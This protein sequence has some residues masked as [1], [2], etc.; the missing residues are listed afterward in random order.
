MWSL[1]TP[2]FWCDSPYE[3][4][5][6]KWIRSLQQDFHQ[7]AGLLLVLTSRTKAFLDF[8]NMDF[9]TTFTLLR[10]EPK[11]VYEQYKDCSIC[12]LLIPILLCY[13]PLGGSTEHKDYASSSS[14]I[15]HS[16]LAI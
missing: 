2:H 6:P 5:E 16:L 8:N 15:R 14:S 7:D 12:L 13:K 1:E 4:P 11:A 9:L 10:E 3:T